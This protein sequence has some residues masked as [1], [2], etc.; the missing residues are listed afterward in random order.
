M[1]GQQPDQTGA[2]ILDA[3]VRVLGDSGFKRATVELVAKEAGVSHMTIYRR[4]PTKGELLQTAVLRE[5]TGLLD[6]AFATTEGSETPFADRTVDAFADVVWGVRT[7]PI[8]VRELDSETDP[9]LPAASGALLE[10]VVPLVRERLSGLAAATGSAVEDTDALTDVFVRMAHSLVLVDRP[11]Q[12]L[13][14][15]TDVVEYAREFFGPYLKGLVAEPD[16][17]GA[18]I[19]DFPAVEQERP[20][21]LRL[22]LAAASLLGVLLLGAGLSAILGGTGKLPFIQPANATET[23]APAPVTEAP[24]PAVPSVGDQS[25]QQ[26]IAPAAVPAQDVPPVYDAPQVRAPQVTADQV[27]PPVAVPSY[28]GRQSGGVGQAVAPTVALAPAPAPAR[29]TAPPPPPPPKPAPGPGPAPGPKPPPGPGPGPGP[30]PAPGPGPGPGP[31]QGPGPG[32]G[33]NHPAN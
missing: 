31:H 1:A 18:Q 17:G 27:A 24:R 4:W 6:D 12:S 30:A 10:T 16:S 8:V 22:Q 7:H 9:V 11:G 29:P 2:K 21:R 20:H 33:P 25:P 19:V 28:P 3:A 23:N 13:A 5:F 32:P 15:K 14:T 26:S